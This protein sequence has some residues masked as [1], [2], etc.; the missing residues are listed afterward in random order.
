M[1]EITLTNLNRC[2][3]HLPE[4]S[5]LHS[6]ENQNCFSYKYARQF[7]KTFNFNLNKI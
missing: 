1:H 5:V 6:L 7:S 3:Y 4:I 2:G